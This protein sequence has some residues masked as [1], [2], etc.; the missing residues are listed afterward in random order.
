MWTKYWCTPVASRSVQCITFSQKSFNPT[1]S[2]L[3]H[4][5]IIYFRCKYSHDQYVFLDGNAYQ[6]SYLSWND[7]DQVKKSIV[8]TNGILFA[9]TVICWGHERSVSEGQVVHS[10]GPTI[11]TSTRLRF[12]L[13]VTW[14]H[15][16]VKNAVIIPTLSLDSSSLFALPTRDAY[17]PNRS[18]GTVFNCT[19]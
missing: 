14:R 7:I 12:K 6:K 11:R 13:K 16:R 19:H 3:Y 15:A 4:T 8:L 2:H 9:R 17:S 5:Y 1:L 18:Y 10:H